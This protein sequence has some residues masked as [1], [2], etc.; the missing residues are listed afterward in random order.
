MTD[1]L[2][3]F[4]FIVAFAA[5]HV[6]LHVFFTFA[7]LSWRSRKT[8]KGPRRTTMVL[9]SPLPSDPVV[10]FLVSAR[11]LAFGSSAPSRLPTGVPPGS[12]W[13]FAW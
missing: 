6:V 10:C 9:R 2:A 7:S 8:R 13:L 4:A 12:G 11:L 1:F 5:L 3:A